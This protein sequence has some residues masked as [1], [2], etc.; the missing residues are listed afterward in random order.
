[1]TG[2]FRHQIGENKS[3]NAPVIQV[4]V[5]CRNCGSDAP[6]EGAKCL[7]CHFP[8]ARPQNVER[9][10]DQTTAKSLSIPSIE[11]QQ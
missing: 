2:N 7:H 1:M 6:G 5:L 4:K 8:L 11:K 9:K 3:D 10:V